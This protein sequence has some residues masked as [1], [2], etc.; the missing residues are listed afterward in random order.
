MRI[1][2]P[3]RVVDE[4]TGGEERPVNPPLLT[5][6]RADAAELSR[7][8]R[9]TYA[10]RTGLADVLTLPGFWS[11]ALWRLGNSWHARGLRVLSRLTY[12][13]NLVVFGADLAPG[14]VVGPGIVMPH[15]VGLALASDVV[16]GARCRVMGLVRIGG[17]GSADRLGHP[18]IEDD[19][20]LLDGVR[21]FGPVTVGARSV[22]GASVLVT[23]DVPPDTTVKLPSPVLEVRPR[24]RRP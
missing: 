21:V 12:F 20:W 24:R 9:R 18:V 4:A 1:A 19:V 10:G 16:L 15:P 7:L 14:A 5:A 17:S 23:E 8:K 11:V 22:I 2:R 6:L 3:M 13:V